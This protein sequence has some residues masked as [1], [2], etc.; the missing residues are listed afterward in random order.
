M[1]RVRTLLIAAFVA[2]LGAACDSDRVGGT[3]AEVS[4]AARQGIQAAAASPTARSFRPEAVPVVSGVP[5]ASF[6]TATAGA[7]PPKSAAPNATRAARIAAFA[8]GPLI[9]GDPW[10]EAQA[11]TV[12]AVRRLASGRHLVYT[13]AGT[14]GRVEPVLGGSV[15]DGRPIVDGTAVAY[16]N[17]RVASAT[18]AGAPLVTSAASARTVGLVETDFAAGDFRAPRYAAVQGCRSISAGTSFIGHYCYANGPAAGSGNATAFAAGPYGAGLP[19]TNVYHSNGWEEEFVVTDSRFGLVFANSAAPIDVEID[20]VQVQAGPTS[21][22][23]AEG[24]TLV[25]DYQGVARRRTVRVVSAAGSIGAA[26]RGVAL[27]A[28]GVVDAGATSNDQLLIFGDSINASVTPASEAG[29]QLL[30]YWVQR[31]LGFGGAVNMAVGGSGYVSQNPNSYNVPT[32]LANAA[33]RALI[34]GYAPNVTHVIVNAGFN[35]RTRPIATVQAAALAS[36]RAL[37]ALLPNAKISISDGWSG[38]SGPDADALALAAGLATT[39]ARWG[40]GNA[41]LIHSVGTSA[42]T[43]YVSGTGDAGTPIMAGN[44]SV[45]TSTDGVHPSP[46]GARYLA[47]RL[48]DDIVS[49][50]GGRY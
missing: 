12:D 17:G 41:R 28:Q 29:A 40:D 24:W 38:S 25:L 15:Q 6:A 32:L 36:W 42:S 5:R 39:F 49:A 23:G 47:R 26:L 8:S 46:A 34:A 9:A 50:W 21:S 4:E 22:T 44:S 31:D 19:A 43:A 11:V 14:T 16:V 37:R 18:R 10:R 45:Y 1:T 7:P 35:D 3:A 2:R 20:G 30:S 48:S 13:Q 27:T 33:N